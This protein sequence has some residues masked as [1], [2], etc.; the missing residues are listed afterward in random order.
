MFNEVNRKTKTKIKN[1]STSTVNKI[2]NDC[3]ELCSFHLKL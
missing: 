2:K 3:K 1:T